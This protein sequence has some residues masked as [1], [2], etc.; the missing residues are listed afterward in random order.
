MS[1]SGN[2]ELFLQE[3]TGVPQE[4]VLAYLSSG[5]RLTNDSIRDLAGAEDEVSIHSLTM[6]SGLTVNWRRYM[7]SVNSLW[8]R[9]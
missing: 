7:S 1:R 6:V 5:S 9:I 2:L 3:E 8:M 4:A